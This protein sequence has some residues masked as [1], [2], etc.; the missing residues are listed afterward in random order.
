MSGPVHARSRALG[1]ACGIIEQMQTVDHWYTE[2]DPNLECT[3][4]LPLCVYGPFVVV[5]Q[6]WPSLPAACAQ[7]PAAW[8]AAPR[9]LVAGEYSI[10]GLFRLQTSHFGKTQS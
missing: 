3:N 8:D 1:I 7:S 2:S 6:V 9:Q 4:D 10:S 5:L